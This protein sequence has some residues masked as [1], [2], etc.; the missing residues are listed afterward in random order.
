MFTWC[1]TQF[2]S[3][4]NNGCLS[5]CH[6]ELVG[7]DCNLANTCEILIICNANM[8]FFCHLMSDE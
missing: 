2:S 7:L 1:F 3:G 6:R 5:T 8:C 4:T